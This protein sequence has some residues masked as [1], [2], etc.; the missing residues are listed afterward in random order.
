MKTD[1]TADAQPDLSL[2]L[3]HR[4]FCWFC[5]TLAHHLRG[6]L[7]Y[8]IVSILYRSLCIFMQTVYTQDSTFCNIQSGSTLFAKVLLLEHL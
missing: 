4:S 2:L 7:V 5:P 8:F 6:C 3:V 1:Q